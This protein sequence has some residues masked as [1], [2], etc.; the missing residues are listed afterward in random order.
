V[1]R[2]REIPKP[3]V[4][5][6]YEMVDLL[7]AAYFLTP[8]PSKDWSHLCASGDD[9]QPCWFVIPREW[10]AA[11]LECAEGHQHLKVAVIE[12]G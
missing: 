2:D 8:I 5:A 9:G 7:P 12:R 1:V 6:Y 3:P 11:L 4:A 10:E